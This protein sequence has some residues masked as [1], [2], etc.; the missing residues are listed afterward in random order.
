MDKTP[1][2]CDY[3]GQVGL[4]GMFVGYSKETRCL[5]HQNKQEKPPRKTLG[6][7]S[8]PS[9]YQEENGSWRGFKRGQNE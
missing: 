8:G 3:H 5:R 9:K 2:F 4:C 6:H 7:Y 1:K